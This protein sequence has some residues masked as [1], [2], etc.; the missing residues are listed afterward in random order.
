MTLAISVSKSKHKKQQWHDLKLNPII[1]Y[2]RFFEVLDLR[3]PHGDH[4]L[5]F[6]VGI[7]WSYLMIILS[8]CL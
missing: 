3:P 5:G 2:G 7:R 4:T 6:T 8:H 1:Y